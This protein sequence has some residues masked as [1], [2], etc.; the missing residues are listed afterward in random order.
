MNVICLLSLVG[1]SFEPPDM[2]IPL[3]I[4]IKVRKL[5]KRF[6][7]DFREEESE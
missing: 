3:G 4:P 2:Y 1:I 7:V 5:V 6:G